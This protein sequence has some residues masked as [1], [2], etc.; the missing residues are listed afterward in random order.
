[1]VLFERSDDRWFAANLADDAPFV[2]VGGSD[3]SQLYLRFTRQSG[4]PWEV[5]L[6]NRSPM[7]L[8][9]RVRFF[10]DGKVMGAAPVTVSP[11]CAELAYL[12]PGQQHAKLNVDTRRMDEFCKWIDPKADWMTAEQCSW[13]TWINGNGLD[14]WPDADQQDGSGRR[15]HFP[16]PLVIY[17]VMERQEHPL[18]RGIAHYAHWWTIEQLAKRPDHF[19]VELTDE[20]IPRSLRGFTATS[21]FN[22]TVDLLYADALLTQ[23]PLAVER[24]RLI[25]ERLLEDAQ[26][27]EHARTCGNVAQVCA[28]AYHVTDDGAFL[29]ASRELLRRDHKYDHD[30]THISILANAAWTVFRFTDEGSD[31]EIAHQHSKAL[32]G[33]VT[34]WS[35]G[36]TQKKMPFHVL[37]PLACDERF[38]LE[39]EDSTLRNIWKW[40]AD[41]FETLGSKKQIW[42]VRGGR[43]LLRYA[44]HACTWLDDLWRQSTVRFPYSNAFPHPE[45]TP[46]IVF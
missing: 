15:M 11:G 8:S 19:P 25:A 28:L 36:E 10:V 17:K 38:A 37:D 16:F 29:D 31:Q 40:M 32:R 27:S 23:S 22:G 43:Y 45:Q 30:T 1:M 7:P 41:A 21:S 6:L 39:G 33:M 35:E 12:A 5:L 3:P 24:I 26:N 34:S 2:P 42:G 14:H 20:H 13:Y 44:P 9:G 46:P 18:L 4:N